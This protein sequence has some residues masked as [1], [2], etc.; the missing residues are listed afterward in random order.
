[1]DRSA[2][3]AAALLLYCASTAC[4]SDTESTVQSSASVVASV[5]LTSVSA[6]VALPATAGAVST[7]SAAVTS[8]PPISVGAP[9]VSEALT[10]V[11]GTSATDVY[12]AGE[13]GSILHFD[14]HAWALQATIQM[15]GDVQLWGK[16]PKSV[17]ARGPGANT[18]AHY[19]GQSWSSQT[20]Y[21]GL[22]L[23]VYGSDAFERFGITSID[24]LGFHADGAPFALSSGAVLEKSGASPG[25]WA[26]AFPKADAQACI[27][28]LYNGGGDS[29]FTVGAY[30]TALT[31]RGGAWRQ[32]ASKSDVH[33]RV[34]WASGPDFA[35]AIGE[36]GAVL[37][38]DGKTL[39][40]T[41]V[42][43]GYV[44]GLWGASRTD[45]FAVGEA[46]W[47]FDGDTW[48]KVATPAGMLSA[49]WGT[50]KSHVWAVGA[51][52]VILFFDGKSWALEHGAPPA[53]VPLSVPATI[54]REP[55][56]LCA[57][58]DVT[59]DPGYVRGKVSNLTIEVLFEQHG[60]ADYR[61]EEMKTCLSQPMEFGDSLQ[62]GIGAVIS[63]AAPMT[64]DIGQYLLIEKD[65]VH[66][67]HASGA[68]AIHMVTARRET[69]D[70]CDLAVFRARQPVDYDFE[71]GRVRV[72]STDTYC[73][74]TG[75]N[76]VSVEDAGKWIELL[77][78][79]NVTIFEHDTDADGKKE[80]YVVSSQGCQQ[81]VRVF[82][83]TRKSG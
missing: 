5:P 38:Y 15:G 2:S 27:G 53:E 6:S 68:S 3:S 28:G 56:P 72:E 8:P 54:E 26:R 46:L 22:A 14:G 48:S 51:G 36:R 47:H 9:P 67:G 57:T 20:D 31:Y 44:T 83:I 49:I 16:G 80:L 30:G 64:V 43:L 4:G 76:K 7:A 78:T 29:L 55:T 35:L 11:W 21:E 32:V 41:G 75:V 73:D 12:A 24:F 23:D 70:M 18:V 66:R 82:R 63:T 71:V 40:P 50:D 52:G 37:E 25:N 13:A 58:K 74:D 17:Y 81:W 65:G 33:L 45:V 77:D 19:D 60:S 1:M 59:A 34:V 79:L 10:A 62:E 42:R 69:F 39:K 61:K